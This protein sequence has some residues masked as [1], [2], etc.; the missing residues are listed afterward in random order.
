M[1]IFENNSRIKLWVFLE[2][3]EGRLSDYV[4]TLRIQGH[5]KHI[6]RIIFETHAK[7]KLW[8][9]LER[10]EGRLSGY[11]I[12]FRIQGYFKDNSRTWTF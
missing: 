4:I 3:Y 11:G 12:T 2:R 7:I 10:Y 5:F 9:S 6:S 8:V 1:D